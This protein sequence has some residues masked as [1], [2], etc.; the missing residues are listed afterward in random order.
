MDISVYFF[1]VELKFML[2]WTVMAANS[3]MYNF[4]MLNKILFLTPI[5]NLGFVR[6]VSGC[7]KKNY[8]FFNPNIIPQLY[9]DL[10]VGM[11]KNL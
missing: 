10:A 6:F 4:S 5:L 8:H 1:S 9:W 11:Q 3:V 2:Q 7:L